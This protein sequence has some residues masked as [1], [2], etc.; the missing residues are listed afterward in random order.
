MNAKFITIGVLR[1]YNKLSLLFVPKEFAFSKPTLTVYPGDDVPLSIP[2]SRSGNIV[3]YSHISGGYINMWRNTKSVVISSV[4]SADAGV[5]EV[6]FLNRRKRKQQG[7]VRIIVQGNNLYM[8]AI[9]RHFIKKT[10]NWLYIQ[11]F[12]VTRSCWSEIIIMSKCP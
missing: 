4:T 11:F 12:K 9:I 7:F 1:I 5:Y 6:F 10:F 2:K 3:W 8:H